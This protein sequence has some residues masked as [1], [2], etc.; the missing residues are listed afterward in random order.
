MVNNDDEDEKDGTDNNVE[1]SLTNQDFSDYISNVRDEYR[2][3]LYRRLIG[4]RENR[5][6][7]ET[8]EEYEGG[9]LTAY[10]HIYGLTR[11][12]DENDPS[13]K[14]AL[15]SRDVTSHSDGVCNEIRNQEAG[16]TTSPVHSENT[17]EGGPDVSS[18]SGVSTNEQDNPNVHS[19]RPTTPPNE[20]SPA[21][22]TDNAVNNSNFCTIL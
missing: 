3:E 4:R 2:R 18:P 9:L 17:Q 6:I 12:V 19:N 22:T 8:D 16:P 13:Y 7:T 11:N 20:S 5:P 10:S 1:E 15:M 21:P 14:N